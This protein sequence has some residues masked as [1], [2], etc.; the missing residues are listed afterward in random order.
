MVAAVATD[1]PLIAAKPAQAVTVAIARPPRL[2]PSQALLARNN[3]RLIPA[4]VAKAPIRMNIGMM[5]RSQSVT[6]RIGDCAKSESA[7]TRPLRY[8]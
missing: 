4:A 7:G 8:Q 2:W 3:S 5:P 6:L 1:E